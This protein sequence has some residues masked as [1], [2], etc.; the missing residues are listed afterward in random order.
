MDG[1][2]RS[3]DGGEATVQSVLHGDPET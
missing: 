2:L 3:A 1:V